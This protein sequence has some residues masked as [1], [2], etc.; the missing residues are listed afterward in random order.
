MDMGYQLDVYGT[1][2]LDKDLTPAQVGELQDFTDNDQQ[3]PSLPGGGGYCTWRLED[4][5]GSTLE[6]NYEGYNR[7]SDSWIQVLIDKFFQPW[8]LKVN[9]EV[10]WQGDESDDRGILKVEDNEVSAVYV[11]DYIKH[12]EEGLDKLLSLVPNQLP[13]LLGINETMD[14]KVKEALA[15]NEVAGK[16]LIKE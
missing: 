6:P 7:Y 1:L 15:S 14:A 13:L 2:S 16:K 4:G 8:G 3:D 9:G 5:S 11:A 12:L 10:T